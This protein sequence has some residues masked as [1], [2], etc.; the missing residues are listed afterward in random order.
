MGVLWN[1]RQIWNYRLHWI[2]FHYGKLDEIS[3]H[4]VEF[5]SK[6]SITKYIWGILSITIDFLLSKFIPVKRYNSNNSCLQW[7][8]IVS[9]TKHVASHLGDDDSDTEKKSIWFL[10]YLNLPYSTYITTWTC[11]CVMWPWYTS[12][13]FLQSSYLFW[14]FGLFSFM[15]TSTTLAG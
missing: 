1:N 15:C 3:I 5:F 12:S 2:L 7:G 6:F 13:D 8:S 11:L 4:V 10:V 14:V 9:I